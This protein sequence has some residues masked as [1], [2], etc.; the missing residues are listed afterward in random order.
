[1]KHRC[2]PNAAA[3]FVLAVTMGAQATGQEQ[4]APSSAASDEVV[5]LRRELA[6]LR[7][8]VNQQQEAMSRIEAEL[9]ELR[10]AKRAADTAHASAAHSGEAAL[11][12][13]SQAAASPSSAP[14]PPQ[15][16]ALEG[17]AER[18][19]FSG[20][21]RVRFEPVLQDLAPARY[22]ARLRVRL[23]VDGKLGEDFTGG[24]Y[25]ATGTVGDDPVSTN[26][27]N[28][29]FFSRKAIGLDRGWITYRPHVARWLELTGGKFAYTWEHTPLTFDT[30]LNPEGFSEKLSF[31][32]DHPFLKN[33]SFVGMQLWLNEAPGSTLPFALGNDSFAVG[34]QV[35]TR[36]RWRKGLTTNFTASALNWRNP[37]SIIQAI[38]ARTLAGNRNTNAT[39]GSGASITYASGFLYAAFQADTTVP[40]PWERFPARLL[41]NF[42][43]NPRAASDQRHGFWGEAQ[44]GR[45]QNRNDVQVAYNFARIE[46]DAVLAA[47]NESEMRA[48]TNVLQHRLA[49]QRLAQKNTT[50]S[51]TGWIGRTLDRSLQNA[52]LP[53]GLA[54]DRKEPYVKRLQFDLTYKF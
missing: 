32:F 9:G 46:Q 38:T 15:R 44:L 10:E 54:P 24:I 28:S 8:Q 22:R 14:A 26:A 48:P 42:V 30:D 35:G 33:L 50:A 36:V 13:A 21:V 1:M 47:F 16:S 43:D 45:L 31:D 18:F 19:R 51:F 7:E 41:L 49:L 53:A 39:L 23:G 6:A 25:L 20:D 52:A 11:R 3:W 2:L 12:P 17:M 40:T 4:P 29:Q 37:D 5:A 27:T 34:G